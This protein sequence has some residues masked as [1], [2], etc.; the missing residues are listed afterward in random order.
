MQFIIVTFHYW[1]WLGTSGE[2]AVPSDESC[3]WF[4]GTSNEVNLLH[5]NL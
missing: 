1:G 3:H 2:G 4:C 5:T